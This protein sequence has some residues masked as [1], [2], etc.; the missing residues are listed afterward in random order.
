MYQ[1]IDHDNKKLNCSQL[2][3]LAGY[4]IWLLD[5]E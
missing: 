3:T 2:I 5:I 4:D 1:D